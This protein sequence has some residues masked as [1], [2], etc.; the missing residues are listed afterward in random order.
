M[1]CDPLDA[2]ILTALWTPY[3]LVS[4]WPLYIIFKHYTMLCVYAPLVVIF[5]KKP[6]Q[7]AGPFFLKLET[8]L[9][10]WPL[11][12]WVRILCALGRR[13][14]RPFYSEVDN[15]ISLG[16]MPVGRADAELLRSYGVGAVVNMCREYAGPE[17]QLLQSGI[18][19]HRAP[20]PD[21]CEPSFSALLGALRFIHNFRVA[22][23]PPLVN[24]N[25]E[26]E[27]KAKRVFVH[28]K[29]GP[30]RSAAVVYCYLLRHRCNTRGG[31]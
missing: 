1:E 14:L 6:Y 13:G 18:V 17:Q 30:A 21:I 25:L 10:D 12:L 16:S 3:L 26:G 20:T 22:Y 7:P 29:A 2:L 4:F 11:I 5:L 23:W 9:W 19:Q 15:F 24:N 31:V 8:V 27:R 28:C